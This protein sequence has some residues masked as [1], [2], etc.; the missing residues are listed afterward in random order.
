MN[1]VSVIVLVV[2]LLLVILALYF[3]HRGRRARSCCGCPLSS[4]CPASRHE[5]TEP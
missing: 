2:V 5:K 1:L 3:L 4:C